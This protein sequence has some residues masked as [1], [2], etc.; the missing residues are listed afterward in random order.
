MYYIDRIIQIKV[1]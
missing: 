1:Q